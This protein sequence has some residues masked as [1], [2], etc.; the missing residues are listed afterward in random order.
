MDELIGFIDKIL[1]Y[2]TWSDRKKI[3]ALLERDCSLYTNLGKESTK[4]ERNNTKKKSRA[5]YRAIK[6]ISKKEGDLFL[7]HIDKE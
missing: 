6:S 1:G 4:K 2:K 5:I 7:Y 3:D